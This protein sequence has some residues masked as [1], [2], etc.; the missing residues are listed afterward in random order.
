M[1]DHDR[2]DLRTLFFSENGGC[3][4]RTPE[5]NI[6][7]KVLALDPIHPDGLDLLRA[8]SDVELV[9]LPNPTEADIAKHIQDAEVVLIRARVLADDM[10]QQATRLRLVSRHGVGCD[11][12][13]FEVLQPLGIGVAIAADSNLISVAEHA[14]TLTL[15][16]CKDLDRANGA[17]RDGK[18]AIR[19]N[20]KA[21]DLNGSQTLVVGFG[22]IGQAYAQRAA[23]F[24]AQITVFDPFR[25]KDASLPEGYSLADSLAEAVSQ[26]DIVSIHM[27]RTAETSNLFD[28]DLLARMKPGSIVVNT[29]RGGIVDEGAMAAALDAGRPGAYATDVLLDEPPHP[30]NPLLGREDVI[31]T[32]H[33]AAMTMQST[34]RMATRSAQNAL[35]FLDGTLREDMIALAPAPRDREPCAK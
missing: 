35:D 6:M 26:A 4:R 25:P 14:M 1:H 13:K 11:N 19:E 3:G 32:P 17:V 9:H 7:A 5:G 34:I 2:H 23:A 24:G 29:A 15:A 12:L 20:L 30:D 31:V 22:R 33:S 10:F 28:G 16:A 8:R 21:R 27:P 18:W